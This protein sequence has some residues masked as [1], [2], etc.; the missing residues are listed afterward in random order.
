MMKTLPVAALLLCSCGRGG[1]DDGKRASCDA[2]VTSAAIAKSLLEQVTLQYQSADRAAAK[3][4]LW[5]KKR[6]TPEQDGSGEYSG[7][8]ANA[9]AHYQTATALCQSVSL[10]HWQLRELARVSAD[11]DIVEAARGLSDLNCALPLNAITSSDPAKRKAANEEWFHR[12]GVALD[13]EAVIV[14]VC[15]EKYGESR[16]T[17]PPPI[18][19]TNE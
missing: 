3:W 1:N 18:L 4:D 8:G 11:P 16:V 14:N 12:R 7:A 10:E 2:I 6:I 5:E 19:L 17:A 13:G 15:R 9:L